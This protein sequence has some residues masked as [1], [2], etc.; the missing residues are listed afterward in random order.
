MRLSCLSDDTDLTCR[1]DWTLGLRQYSSYKGYLYYIPRTGRHAGPVSF[2]EPVS[3][4]GDLGTW[5]LAEWAG[6]FLL[7]LSGGISD[8][9]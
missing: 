7:V 6:R 8:I 5:A 3:G 9:N 4:E 2:G 1:V